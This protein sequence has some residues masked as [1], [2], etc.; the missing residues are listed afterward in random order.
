MIQA[1]LD[2]VDVIV[3]GTVILPSRHSRDKIEISVLGV[4]AAVVAD[5]HM[6]R[7]SARWE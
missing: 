5:R 7:Q 6:L 2:T 3:L 4:V 1:F